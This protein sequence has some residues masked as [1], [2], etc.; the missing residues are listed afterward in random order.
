MQFVTTKHFSNLTV[1]DIT[2][3]AGLNRTTFYLHYAGVPELLDDCAHI[4]FEQLREEVYSKQPLSNRNDAASVT[5]FVECV[6]RHLEHHEASYRAML[7]R[8]IRC[9]AACF[10]NYYQS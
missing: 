2:H 4:L 7:G 1:Q 8:V 9:F 5:P 6:F 10:R 3:R